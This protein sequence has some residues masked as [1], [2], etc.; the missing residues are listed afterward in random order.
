MIIFNQHFKKRIVEPISR[1]NESLDAKIIELSKHLE[2]RQSITLNNFPQERKGEPIRPGRQPSRPAF[3]PVR[4]LA[5]MLTEKCNL[6]CAYCLRDTRD[7]GKEIP[8]P[9]FKR[10]ILS[11]YRFGIR[12]FNLTGGEILVYP[13]WRELIKLIGVLK[14]TVF[15]E[16]NGY[17]LKE[18]DIVFLKNTLNN[19]ISKVLVSLDSYRSDVHDQFRGKGAFDRAVRAIKLLHKYN[20]PVEV[21]ALLT[22]LN[23][24]KEEDI[25]NYVAFNKKLG[26]TEIVLGEAVSLGRAKNSQFLLKENQRRQISQILAKHNYFKDES[27]IHFRPGGF[28]LSAN[29][30]PCH[31]LGTEIA[32]SPYGLHPCIFQIDTVKIGDFDDL[33]KLLYSNFLGSLYWTGAAMQQCFKKETFF[34]CSKCIKYLPAWLSYIKKDIFLNPKAK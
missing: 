28:L 4:T 16:T 1:L 21:N 24:M 33:E 34:S 12:D 9:V 18:E 22:P 15:F 27:T 10:I 14:S 7:E 26:V 13:H 6:R 2:N 3:K 30:N 32:V 11:A 29:R 20:I 19:R 5:L 31:R 23:F 17:D 8:L 25:L